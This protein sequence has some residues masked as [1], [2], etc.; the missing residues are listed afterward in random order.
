MIAATAMG[1]AS[2]PIGFAVSALGD[3][4]IKAELGI[5]PDVTTFAPIIVGVPTAPV[6]PTTRREPLIWT[7][8]R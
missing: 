6:S 2:C 3:P 1:L 8:K 4:A 5:P 7:W